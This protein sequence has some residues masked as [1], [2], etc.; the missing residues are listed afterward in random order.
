MSNDLA[1]LRFMFDDELL[2]GGKRGFS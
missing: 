1:R 2:V